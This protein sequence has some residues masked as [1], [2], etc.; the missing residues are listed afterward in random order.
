MVQSNNAGWIGRQVEEAR[1]RRID[2]GLCPDCGMKP[3]NVPVCET[4]GGTGKLPNDWHY[5]KR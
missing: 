3:H 1:Q 5:R 2:K 4:C